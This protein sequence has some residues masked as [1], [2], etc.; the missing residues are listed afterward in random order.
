MSGERDSAKPGAAM[1]PTRVGAFPA[2][3]SLASGRGAS[4]SILIV[5][6]AMP[7]DP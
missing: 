7:A 1:I 6:G 5:M 4:G 3:P 2:L